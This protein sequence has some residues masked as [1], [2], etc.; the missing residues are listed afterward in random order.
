MR[1]HR[2]L[3][4][5]SLALHNLVAEKI[6]QNPV[7]LEK[8][9]QTLANWRTS[10]CP[11]TQPYLDEWEQILNADLETCLAAITED[12]EHANAL[13]QSSPFCGILSHQ[14]RFE[15]LRQWRHDHAA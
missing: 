3:D 13:R 12:S 14:E 9:K 8:A 6:R 5:R 11:A 7:L 15:F 10:V 4:Q 2:L 1:D